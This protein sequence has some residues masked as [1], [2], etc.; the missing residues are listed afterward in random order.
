MA[1]GFGSRLKAFQCPSG[2]VRLDIGVLHGSR[3]H[4]IVVFEDEHDV[5]LIAIHGARQL[6]IAALSCTSSLP[7]AHDNKQPLAR[8]LLELQV[9]YHVQNLADWVLDAKFVS[10]SYLKQDAS[11]SSGQTNY[12][13]DVALGMMN[14]YVELWRIG[15]HHGAPFPGSSAAPASSASLLGTAASTERLLLYAMRLA[16]PTQL[17][18]SESSIPS[19]NV[20]V[21]SGEV[22]FMPILQSSAIYIYIQG[23]GCIIDHYSV[24][25]AQFSIWCLYGLLS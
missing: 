13:C 1:A 14:N 17:P 25:Q 3:I 15:G 2:A 18:K 12:C 6:V 16:V 5:A 20:V 4:G 22:P 23:Q 9:I 19:R 21:A 8:S 24:V 10:I 7:A 11:F